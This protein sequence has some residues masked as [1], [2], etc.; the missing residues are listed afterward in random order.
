MRALL[1]VVLLTSTL[2]AA[3]KRHGKPAGAPVPPPPAALEPGVVV[4]EVPAQLIRVLGPEGAV[5]HV[6]SEAGQLLTSAWVPFDYPGKAGE[7][8]R[9][10]LVT[11]AG[12][13][14]FDAKLVVRPNTA[15]VVRAKPRPAALPV[16]APPAIAPPVAPAAPKPVCMTDAEFQTLKRT[17]EDARFSDDMMGVLRTAA[18]RTCF[19]VAQVGGLI[20]LF[21]H[22][23]HKVAVVELL[24]DRL[25]D[26][27]NA[28]TLLSHFTFSA[29]KERVQGLLQ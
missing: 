19:S 24:R 12:E 22:S 14:L 20:D 29:D 11:P 15:L 6:W 9:L 2:A 13:A 8:Y 28:Y 26:K 16:P 25:S 10:L 7:A 21:P 18:A 3:Q 17:M 23:D 5:G 27:K 4:E 1:F